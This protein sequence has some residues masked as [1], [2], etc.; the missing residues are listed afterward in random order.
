MI[1][2]RAG[3]CRCG[4]FPLDMAVVAD[5]VRERALRDDRREVDDW[6]EVLLPMARHI[7]EGRKH[8]DEFAY[9]LGSTLIADADYNYDRVPNDNARR[10]SARRR[11]MSRPALLR[12]R[13]PAHGPARTGRDRV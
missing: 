11:P 4:C 2:P 12:R 9:V 6:P 8:A 5:K 3:E 13:Q 7:D 10:R 1:M